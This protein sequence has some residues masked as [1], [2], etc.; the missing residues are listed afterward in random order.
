MNEKQAFREFHR[1][2]IVRHKTFCCSVSG[3][4][5]D[6]DRSHVVK[7]TS[8]VSQKTVVD[9]IS[10]RGL[11]M[12]PNKTRALMKLSLVTSLEELPQ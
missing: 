9:V 12:L 11:N 1:Q 4:I 6:L 2:L 3:E 5:L 7:F 8:P 10:D